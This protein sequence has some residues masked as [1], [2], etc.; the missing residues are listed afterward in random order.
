MSVFF[1][2]DGE[3]ISAYKGENLVN[4]KVKV[5]IQWKSD[6]SNDLVDGS[7]TPVSMPRP[8]I[9][10]SEEPRTTVRRSRT[11][12]VSPPTDTDDRSTNLVFAPRTSRADQPQ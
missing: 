3:V 8:T 9:Q 6:I 7:R 2:P 12:T 4:P 5:G 11:S 10:L 1:S